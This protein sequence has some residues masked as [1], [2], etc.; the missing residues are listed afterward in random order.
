MYRDLYEINNHMW[1]RVTSYSLCPA[2]DSGLRLR[3]P[4][5]MLPTGP[6]TRRPG[7]LLS[8]AESVACTLAAVSTT[9]AVAT[10]VQDR[11]LSLA[12]WA[13][14]SAEPALNAALP[15]QG[16]PA[17]SS[18]ESCACPAYQYP[19]D[20]PAVGQKEAH[21]SAVCLSP[22]PVSPVESGSMMLSLIHI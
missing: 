5:L 12:P 22:V 14:V 16:F 4:V 19:C 18:A 8:P 20:S 21:H 9:T 10:R 7:C 3:P 6:H 15:P 17:Q 11:S 13:I 1:L 2:T